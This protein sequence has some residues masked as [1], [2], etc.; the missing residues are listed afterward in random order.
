MLP[1]FP[2]NLRK[3]LKGAP[4]PAPRNILAAAVEGAQVDVDTALRIESRYFIELVTGQV[5]EEHDQGVLLRHADDGGARVPAGGVRPVGADE[6]RRARR[7]DD[8]RRDRVRAA[9]GPAVDVV[10]KDVTV[11]AAAKGKAYSEGLV[12]K[13]VQRGR[14][15]PEKGA[16]LLD[17]ITP[18]ADPADL[19]GCDL[20]IEAVFESGALKQRGVRRGREGRRART[21]CCAPTPPRCRSPRSPR[22]STGPADFVGLHFFS[23]VDKMP[24][25][26]IIRGRETSDAA[27][28]RAF[29]VAAGCA[30]PRSSSTTAAASSPAG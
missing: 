6:G 23:P 28:A 2:A 21:R 24:L 5:V 3:Q 17:R 12:A 18:T 25:I 9:R 4:Y 22:A 10:L 8:G 16:A 15:T 14:T 20:V 27:L 19:A 13:A 7:R 26:E 11:E 29:D 30:R 1:A